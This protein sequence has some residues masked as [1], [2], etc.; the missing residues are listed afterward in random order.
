[1]LQ[2]VSVFKRYKGERITSK[3]PAY[4]KA[5]WWV[6]KRLK[7]HKT[8][9]Q[10]IPEARTREQAELAE[11]RLIDKLF[12]RKYG[13]NDTETT[14]GQFA[15]GPYMRYVTA[16]N[17]NIGAKELYIRTLN[18]YWEH[19]LV[20]DI[21]PQ[22][23]RDVQQALRHKSN[24]RRK[25]S[26]PLSDS[27]VNRIMSTA[28]KLFNVACGEGVIER[29]PM[30]FVRPLKE[31]KARKRDL[32]GDEKTALWMELEKD[33]FLRP[34]VM[35]AV[36]MPV[37][38]GQLLALK[39]TDVDFD[40]RLV[41]VIP[42]KGR[43]ERTIPISDAALRILHELCSQRRGR[44]FPVADFRRRWTSALLRAGIN[45]PGGTRE[46]NFH[47][48]DLR[49]VFASSLTRRG[50]NPKAIQD[51]FSHSDTSIT[52]GYIDVGQELLF[53]AINS[54]DESILQPP[55]ENDGPPN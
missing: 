16:E 48:H 36:L 1:M 19:K 27:S 8:I 38:K 24:H 30:Q 33:D 54:V 5:R 43:D 7:G 52:D 35:L 26:K 10:S 20:S 21:T 39:D 40:K 51:L 3:H 42:S 34:I 14:F 32:T 31:P 29:N 49:T 17:V 46:Q 55:Q 47:F 22:D 44:L 23:C 15:A 4:S 2:L 45:K 53:Q 12:N 11:R 9:H 37:R 6:Y 41:T 25:D 50:I 18:K 28:S 13:V